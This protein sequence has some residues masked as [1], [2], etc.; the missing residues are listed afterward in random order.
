MVVVIVLV[1]CWC[2]CWW[3]GGNVT[4]MDVLVSISDVSMVV[5]EMC[6]R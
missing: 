2:Q 1:M 5:L 6:W 4:D 3:C